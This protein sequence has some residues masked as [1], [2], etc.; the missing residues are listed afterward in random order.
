MKVTAGRFYIYDPVMLD[1]YDA[2]TNLR[3]GDV[4]RVVN[5]PGCPK[6]N[7]MGH[8]HV[9]DPETGHFIGL[10]CANSLVAFHTDRAREIVAELKAQLK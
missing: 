8:C 7:T 4:V 1:Q 10:I 9:E 2:R 6:A 3:K 5:L